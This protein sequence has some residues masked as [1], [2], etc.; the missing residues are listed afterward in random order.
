MLNQVKDLILR[1][2]TV[3]IFKIFRKIFYFY[4]L[5]VKRESFTVE[6]SRWFR[7]KGDSTHRL[8]YNL[9]RE[10]IVFDLGGYIGDFTSN[11]YDKFGCKI[12]LFEPHPKYYEICVS[13]FKDNPNIAVFNFGLSNVNG[14]FSLT[15]SADLSSFLDER[16]ESEQEI[17]CEVKNIMSVVTELGITKIDLIKINVEGGEYPILEYMI[18]NDLLSFIDNYQIQFH[19][20]VI[21]AIDKRNHIVQ[22]LSRTHTRTWCYEFVWENWTKRGL[23]NDI[24]GSTLD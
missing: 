23:V 20:F 8:N 3:L 1:D 24:K 12:F 14:N 13:R 5:H 15:D 10:S 2:P 18:E 11:I 22:A 7:D 21:D 16:K 9:N 19:N 6:V 4:R 17:I